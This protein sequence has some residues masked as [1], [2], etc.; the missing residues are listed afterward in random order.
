MKKQTLLRDSIPGEYPPTL[1]PWIKTGRK[2]ILNILQFTLKSGYVPKCFLTNTGSLCKYLCFTYLEKNTQMQ[3][4]FSIKETFFKICFQHS[5]MWCRSIISK[6][7]GN[8]A[9]KWNKKGK[10]KPR[11]NGMNFQMGVNILPVFKNYS[12]ESHVCFLF[13]IYSLERSLI[14]KYTE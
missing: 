7:L 8:A 6:N 4:I 12:E 13:K 9:S 5:Q 14:L 10:P 1:T 2:Q 3:S 11:Y